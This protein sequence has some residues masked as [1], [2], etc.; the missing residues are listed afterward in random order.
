MPI[1]TE[2]KSNNNNR[3]VW[4]SHNI[5][6][7]NNSFV[8]LPYKAKHPPPTTTN[9]VT[10][11]HVLL[12]RHPHTRTHTM[13]FPFCMDTLCIHGCLCCVDVDIFFYLLR[14][15]P[16]GNFVYCFC[17]LG[18]IFI[19]VPYSTKLIPDMSTLLKIWHF[20]LTLH[21]IQFNFGNHTNKTHTHTTMHWIKVICLC[22]RVSFIYRTFAD[23]APVQFYMYV[24]YI[25]YES[26]GTK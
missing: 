4:V 10:S 15:C 7:T 6:K 5:N 21:S 19:F 17:V 12:L 18:C 2:K 22:I 16:P 26:T 3:F 23:C 9:I 13:L 24:K 20:F 8:H 14:L 25:V 1:R 11:L